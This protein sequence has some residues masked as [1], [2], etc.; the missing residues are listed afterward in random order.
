[1]TCYAFEGTH[2][3]RGRHFTGCE[4]DECA[5]CLRCPEN[6]CT[7][8][9]K[10]THLGFGEATCA[11]CIGRARADLRDLLDLYAA[12]P[13]EAQVRG[14]SSEAFGLH[15]PVA[16]PEA[17]SHRRVSIMAGRINA[18]LEDEDEHHPLAVLGRWVFMIGTDYADEWTGELT[19]AGAVDYLDR[20]LGRIAHDVGQDFGLF[21]GEVRRC[22]THLEAVLHD[23]E[24]RD[25][26]RVPCLECGTRLERRYGRLAKEDH[27]VCPNRKCKRETY[28]HNEFVLA[29]RQWLDDEGAD[30]YVKMQD[31]RD[32]VDR[33]KRTWSKWLRYWYV[34]SYQDRLTGQVWVWWP[35]VR[36]VEANTPRRVRAAA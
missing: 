17:F 14:V 30:R 31:A 25:L 29:K 27:H 26:T 12:L 13:S 3:L 23:G 6:H 10:G 33:P 28:A 1:M 8:C 19:L 16:D 15:G 7:N 21:A 32:A 22:K 35:D 18:P 2:Y 20:R 24:Q 4:D 36:E 5:G 11:A 9:R 34:R